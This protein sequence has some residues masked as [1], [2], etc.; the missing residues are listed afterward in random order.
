MQAHVR[1]VAAPT[2][3]V[4]RSHRLDIA[5]VHLAAAGATVAAA[6]EAW[7]TVRAAA[8]PSDQGVTRSSTVA[9]H[10]MPIRITT[11]DPAWLSGSTAQI[12]AKTT[13]ATSSA[14]TVRS[15]ARHVQATANTEL[16]S[17]RPRNSNAPQ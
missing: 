15:A 14:G 7:N 6:I 12:T 5:G 9:H 10:S 2:T 13:T 1:E 4:R 17:T 11:S 3:A 8:A 16:V